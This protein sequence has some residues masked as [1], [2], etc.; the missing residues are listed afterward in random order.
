MHPRSSKLLRSTWAAAAGLSAVVAM[1]SCA[2]PQR[3]EP[4][5]GTQLTQ[6]VSPPPRL[7]PPEQ[8]SEA[9]RAMLKTRMASH[10]RDMADLMSAILVLDY[11]PI[12]AGSLRIAGD[13]SLSRP[14]SDDATKRP[15]AKVR[16]TSPIPT[17]ACRRS[18]FDATPP[19]APAG[20]SRV[21]GAQ[22]LMPV[23][24]NV[25]SNPSVN[26]AGCDAPRRPLPAAPPGW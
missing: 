9:A 7:R 24:L 14:L 2:A 20:E 1:T 3:A 17:D 8:L 16:S 6:A 18:A 23:R 25:R 4:V 19:T 12:R 5:Q 22:R 13:A 15:A 21:A 11:E 10:A 26:C